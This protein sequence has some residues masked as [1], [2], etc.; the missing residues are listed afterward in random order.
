MGM[1]EPLRDA[2]GRSIDD[3]I[4]DRGRLRVMPDRHVATVD[5]RPL[6][7]TPREFDLLQFFVRNPGRLL[8]RE[9]IAAQVWSSA[10]TGR[11]IDVHVARLRGKLPAGAIQTV[12]R[13]GY[14]FVLE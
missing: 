1:S 6:Q 13:L 12:I 8:R 11:T 4:I 14:R 10:P 7:L 3:E 5:G 9:H 2:S